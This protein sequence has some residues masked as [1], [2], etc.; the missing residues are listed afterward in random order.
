MSD[1]PWELVMETNGPFEAEMLRGL[2]EASQ[3]PVFLSQE[4]AGRAFGLTMGTLGLVQILVPLSKVELARKI[5]QDYESGT[6]PVMG[7]VEDLPEST[8]PES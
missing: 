8:D 2:L 7:S 5:L 6:P 1:D 3:I 4:G